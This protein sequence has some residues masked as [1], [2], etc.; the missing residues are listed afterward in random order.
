[1]Y[2]Q[3]LL[4]WKSNV[5]LVLRQFVGLGIRHAM[6][7]PHMSSV[8]CPAL[9]YFPT[10]Y[11]KGTILEENVIDHKMCVLIFCTSFV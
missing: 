8:T 2:V 11:H 4:Q 5:L 1:M 6:R 10:L 3:L 7:M 9:Q